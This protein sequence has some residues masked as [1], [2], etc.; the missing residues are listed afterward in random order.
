MGKEITSL[1]NTEVIERNR[2]YFSILIDIQ[3]A[4]EVTPFLLFEFSSFCL[5]SSL[6]LKCT[7]FVSEFSD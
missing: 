5:I 4:A 1:V 7:V 3:G 2:Y 6:F